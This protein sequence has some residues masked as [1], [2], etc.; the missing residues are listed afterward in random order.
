[1]YY[2]KGCI[3]YNYLISNGT[4]F[5]SKLYTRK[6]ILKKIAQIGYKEVAFKISDTIQVSSSDVT[7]N[8]HK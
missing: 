6:H 3:L 5:S 1:M 7:P 2:Y 4:P 8:T